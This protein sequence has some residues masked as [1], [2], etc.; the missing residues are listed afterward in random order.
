MM[1]H[2]LWMVAFWLGMGAAQADPGV[3]EQ[4]LVMGS[5]QPLS[6]IAQ[7]FSDIAKSTEAYFRYI[8]DQGG[9][10]GRLL[11]YRYHDDG[12]QPNKTREVVRQLVLQEQVFL[13]LNG[14]GTRPHQSVAPWLQSMKVPDF[15]IA[16][17]SSEW[18]EP[19][20][21]T[22]FAFYPTPE[23][24]ARALAKFISDVHY[25]ES[26]VVWHSDEPAMQSAAKVFA[27]QLQEKE[28][29]PLLIQHQSSGDDALSSTFDIEQLDPQ[30]V[31]L[32]TGQTPAAEFLEHTAAQGLQ[33]Q[34]YLGSDLADS[35][36]L[37]QFEEDVIERIAL[38]TAFPMAAQTD[39]PGIREH[40]R[41]LKTYLPGQKM[42]RWTIYGQAV[43]EAMVEILRQNGRNLTRRSVVQ[44]AEQ[45]SF[46]QGSL[47]PPIRLSPRQHQGVTHL[48]II[49]IQQGQFITISEWIDS[50]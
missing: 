45:M 26:I 1:K 11:N 33:A 20:Q 37:S 50:Q 4:E 49:Q 12:F 15:F 43:G 38:L 3:H 2:L 28:I 34:R 32:F 17:S 31:V 23:I 16:S 29:E 14:L 6:G 13:I 9:V 41:I 19:P 24:E 21:K 46:W 47:T 25:D 5:H 48:Q 39:H 36:W 10:H 35:Q 44:T 22:T 18:T 7:S 8:N 40:Q 42:N 27:Q 30:V